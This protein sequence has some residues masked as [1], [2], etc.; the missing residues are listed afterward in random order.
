MKRTQLTIGQRVAA[1]FALLLFIL[2]A[3]AVSVIVNQLVVQR[4][5]NFID[6]HII[7][8]TSESGI[9]LA[10][11]DEL[12][13]H[14]RTF[15]LK[16]KQEDL[17]L[18]YAALVRVKDS[19]KEIGAALDANADLNRGLSDPVKQFSQALASYEIALKATVSG[20]AALEEQRSK[21]NDAQQKAESD[22]NELLRG[23]FAASANDHQ[24]GK[25]AQAAGRLSHINNLVSILSFVESLATATRETQIAN[26]AVPLE[27]ALSQLDSNIL[28][29]NEI[30]SFLIVPANIARANT[31]E[32]SLRSVGATAKTYTTAFKALAE[33]HTARS[34]A[35]T[36]AVKS[37]FAVKAAT[38]VL[39]RANVDKADRAVDNLSFATYLGTALGLVIG[40]LS[41][42]LI[43]C[44]VNKA[45]TQTAETLTQGSLQVASAS[46]EVSS[47]SQSLAEGAS[48]QAASLEE[49]SSSIEEL[50]S[51]TKRNA[52]N[53]QSGKTASNHARSAAETGASE[54]VR[55]QAAMN[56]IQQSSSD[57]SKII[58]TIDEIAF[59]T[60]I[61]ALNAAVEAAR[62]GEAGAGFA[63]VADEVRSLAQR[64]AI[65]AKETA[66][67]IADATQKSAQ[68]VELSGRVS[69]SLLEIVEKSREV[70]RLVAEVT[71]ASREQSEG[72]AQINV[73]VSQMDKV[74]QSNAAS[75][76]ETAS[77]AEELNAQS[78][79]L[80]QA[81]AQLA[82]MVGIVAQEASAAPSIT[83][84]KAARNAHPESTAPE[85]SPKLSGVSARTRPTA[86]APQTAG[87]H[88][89]SQEK[90]SFHD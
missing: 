32:T 39:A 29:L 85:G 88:G 16:G 23:M 38:S 10:E 77:A 87:K 61:L 17:D 56:A 28:K 14:G 78:A 52:E 59:Q 57:I 27:K 9:L 66:E 72:L 83:P 3:V 55:M 12:R 49:I 76:E 11:M 62:A 51:M 30:R 36:E 45:L 8:T 19:Q 46:G 22:T 82:A 20:Q 54:M 37:T 24:N 80:Q 25:D 67:K 2:L 40:A 65:A 84:G 68:G 31:V 63:V 48:E 43:I 7:P 34:R 21:I 79:E 26:D 53:A 4:E 69:T 5:V 73:A 50:A 70:D 89:G 81:A 6:E 47:S 74:T 44:G 90:L 18:A 71:T 86:P 33:T 13:L 42:G 41:A 58:K 60:N 35:G 75:A 15:G 1:G 64:S